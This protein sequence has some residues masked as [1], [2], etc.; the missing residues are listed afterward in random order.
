MI[1][2]AASA[3][4]PRRAGTVY[5]MLAIPVMERVP[6]VRPERR[7][8]LAIWVVMV[9]VLVLIFGFVPELVAHQTPALASAVPQSH[10]IDPGAST[11]P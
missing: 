1:N 11:T 9:G 10:R 4:S 2:A 6:L 5:P 3:H 7:P 8:G